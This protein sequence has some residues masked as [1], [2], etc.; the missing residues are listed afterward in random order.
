MLRSSLNFQLTGA[1]M[2]LLFCFS[3]LKA[4]PINTLFELE[5]ELWVLND[6]AYALIR[7]GRDFTRATHLLDSTLELAVKFEFDSLESD[8]YSQKST[9][10]QRL[11]DLEPAL[12]YAWHALSIRKG[13]ASKGKIGDSH[14]GLGII[15]KKLGDLDSAVFHFQKGL[16]IWQM[17]GDESVVALFQN[18]LADALYH[19][20]ELDKALELAIYSLESRI[21]LK[22]KQ[23]IAYTRL[24]LG[25]IYLE[26][27]A[28]DSAE[29]QFQA[30]LKFAKETKNI[31]LEVKVKSCL[32]GLFLN[33]G[34]QKEA[35]TIGEEVFQNIDEYIE[36]YQIENEDLGKVSYLLGILWKSKKDY[37]KSKVYFKQAMAFSKGINLRNEAFANIDLGELFLEMEKYDSAKVHLK[38]GLELV[39]NTQQ[40]DLH[41][42]IL[43][44]L[45]FLNAQLGDYDQ[46]YQYSQ[47]ED[48]LVEMI[49]GSLRRAE[50]SHFDTNLKLYE[51]AA[52]AKRNAILRNAIILVLLISLIG[53]ILYFQ[54]RRKRLQ[55]QRIVDEKKAEIAKLIQENENKFVL[56][57][58][59]GQE[60]ERLRV[61]KRLHDEVGA[62]LTLASKQIGENVPN[63]PLKDTLRKVSNEI[64]NISQNLKS[65]V[66]TRLGLKAAIEELVDKLNQSSPPEIEQYI[67]IDDSAE[68]DSN[69]EMQ[70]YPIIIELLNN[71]LKHAN[72]DLVTIYL[73]ITALDC[74]IMV[75]DDGQGISSSLIRNPTGDGMRNIFSRVKNLNGDCEYDSQINHGTTV[76]I[77]IPIASAK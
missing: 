32:S 72:A 37:E 14:N 24:T 23:G 38:K 12:N 5:Q 6:T 52:A 9:L 41:R 51:Q 60:A 71:S 53:L 21:R 25:N 62:L 10:A 39:A 43:D 58:S 69:F 3:G 18:N 59:E 55:Q 66:L 76:K 77:K 64:Y 7:S 30:L 29:S 46:A 49:D 40:N 74:E 57:K 63:H 11:D 31:P 4:E 17:I 20:G 22:K 70:V 50:A 47:A 2:C 61:A 13:L 42:R 35:L 48:S 75:E 36:V 68:L 28:F 44:D 26:L 33:S 15:H 56:A 45:A 54:Q 8:C 27:G 67:T 16:E 1:F 19:K 65:S 34:R 73:T